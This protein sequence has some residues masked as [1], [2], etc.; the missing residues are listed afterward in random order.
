MAKSKQ[1][2]RFPAE[3]LVG[4]KSPLGGEGYAVIVPPA[5]LP[6]LPN[7]SRVGRYQLVEV[8]E[9]EQTWALKTVNDT[10]RKAAQ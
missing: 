3:L 9:V 10:Y 1:S 6:L 4:Y 5:D 7:K 8:A 2:K